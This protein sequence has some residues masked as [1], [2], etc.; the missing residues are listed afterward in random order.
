MYIWKIVKDQKNQAIFVL[1]DIQFFLRPLSLLLSIQNA[2][3]RYMHIVMLK[4]PFLLLLRLQ[5]YRY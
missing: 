1:L 3:A 4:M 5:L 2:T